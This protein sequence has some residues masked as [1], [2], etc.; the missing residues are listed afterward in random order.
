METSVTENFKFPGLVQRLGTGSVA[1]I[2]RDQFKI[3][4]SFLLQS[5]K[6]K[7]VSITLNKYNDKWYEYLNTTWVHPE[8]VRE[9]ILNNADQYTDLIIN[10]TGWA[11]DIAHGIAWYHEKG[12][13]PLDLNGLTVRSL[14]INQNGMITKNNQYVGLGAYGA[15]SNINAKVGTNYN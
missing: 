2:V 5:I 14:T 11:H 1:N 8:K 4:P 13:M 7:T 12:L 6:R 10:F 15:F 3:N 9:F